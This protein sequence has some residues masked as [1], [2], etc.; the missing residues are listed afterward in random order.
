MEKIIQQLNLTDNDK[1]LLTAFNENTILSDLIY[2]C[3]TVGIYTNGV[4][5]KDRENTPR[6]NWALSLA[7]SRPDLSDEQIGQDIRATANGLRSL[8]EAFDKIKQFKRVA[9]PLPKINKAK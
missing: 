3:L 8:E 1:E 2:K 7:W 5:F 9:T 4:V 6:I